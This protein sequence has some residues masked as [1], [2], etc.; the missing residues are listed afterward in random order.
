M[1]PLKQILFPLSVLKNKQ[2]IE[3]HKSELQQLNENLDYM[4]GEDIVAEEYSIL[5]G[6][7]LLTDTLISSTII[8]ILC[9]IIIVTLIFALT[10]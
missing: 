1:K 6:R 4:C 2:L 7:E 9:T 10:Y 8:G 3:K 5:T